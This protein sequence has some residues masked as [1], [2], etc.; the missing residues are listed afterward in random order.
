MTGNGDNSESNDENDGSN[1]PLVDASADV[2]DGCDSEAKSEVNEE[3]PD[4]AHQSM[5]ARTMRPKPSCSSSPSMSLGCHHSIPDFNDD[6]KSE[7]YR[8]VFYLLH[9]LIF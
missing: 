5:Q 7:V 9:P 3:E 2:N 6:E 4:H 8:I 1:H